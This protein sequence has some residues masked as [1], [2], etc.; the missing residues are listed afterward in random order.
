MKEA[1][2]LNER[3]H[4]PKPAKL[5]ALVAAFFALTTYVEPGARPARTPRA[6]GALTAVPVDI[7]PGD[8]D[9][10]RVGDLVYRRGWVLTSDT[11]RFGAISALHVAQ[12][13]VTAVSDSGDVM[14]LP[15][16]GSG[17]ARVRI[18]ALP[19]PYGDPARKRNRDTESLAVSDG[20]IW[21]GFE[22]NNLV[23]RYRRSDWHLEG[24]ARPESMRDWPR[25]AGTEAMVRLPDG[26]FLVFG[27]GR[28]NGGAFSPVI[29]FAGD[30]SA[31]GTRALAARFRRPAGYR[32]TDAAL[33]PDGRLLILNRRADVLS[34]ISAKLVVADLPAWREGATIAGREIATL[35]APLTV[36]NMEALSVA[37][38]DGRTI[39]RIASDDNYLKIQRTLLLE[40]ELG[41]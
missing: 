10:R 9:Q 39:V 32:V 36:D 28:D 5:L 40:F 14:L 2:F 27:E 31:N 33:L 37:Q 23:A 29:L 4:V 30:P 24:F 16:P 19:V 3:R 35:A 41:E 34:G 13:Q 15:L 22:R 21:F 11:P 25:N 1:S 17:P 7:V 6:E 38:E 26:R 8:P 12:G 20:T 18:V